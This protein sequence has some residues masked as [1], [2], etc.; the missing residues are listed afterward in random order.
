M[1]ACPAARTWGVTHIPCMCLFADKATHLSCICLFASAGRTRGNSRHLRAASTG[2][3][4]D[5]RRR[6]ALL[7]G[8][9]GGSGYGGGWGGGGGGGGG[10]S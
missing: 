7:S 1:L 3:G 5:R 8:L 10:S 6:S 4:M 2:R 9:D